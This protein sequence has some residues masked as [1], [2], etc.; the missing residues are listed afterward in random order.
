MDTPLFASAAAVTSTRSPYAYN[1]VRVAFSFMA[2]LLRWLQPMD[3]LLG[4]TLST[5]ICL[6]L[7]CLLT[8]TTAVRVCSVRALQYRYRPFLSPV[9]SCASILVQE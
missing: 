3:C 2:S 9:P 7:C 6:F 4:S 8:R 5:A 1:L